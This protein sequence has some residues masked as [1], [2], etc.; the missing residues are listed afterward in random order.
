MAN[1]L[2][3]WGQGGLPAHLTDFFAEESN[4][5]DKVSVPSLSYE[6]KAWTISV[7][8]N[9][10]RIERE[11]DGEMVAV[12][13]MRVIV[14]DYAKRR[15]RAYYPGSY[16]PSKVQ[17]P[18]CWSDDGITPDASVKEPQHS[19]CD[20]CP[21]AIKGSKMDGDKARVACSQHRM[22]AVVPANKLDFTPLRLKLAITSDWDDQS[23]DLEAERWFSFQKYL[24]FLKANRV[25][26][27]AGLVTKMKFDP[28]VQYPKV[29]FSPERP[30][31]AEE[32]EAIKP[33]VKSE[34]VQKLLSG[35]WTPAG[36]DGK[37]VDRS[38]P[39]KDPAAAEKKAAAAATAAPAKEAPAKAA[40][41][42]EEP[43]SVDVSDDD[44]SFVPD[45]LKGK[46]AEG[47]AK[48]APAKAAPPKAAE[49][50]AEKA[51]AKD[52]EITP[53]PKKEEASSVQ[54]DVASLLDTW[55]ED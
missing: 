12:P 44:D 10:H 27:T 18:E 2:T 20:G 21:M 24:D 51:P 28:N 41:P 43:K 53:P 40:P 29:I 13:V 4:I 32:L 52:G 31:T 11:V 49:K 42:K 35:T 55:G 9:K 25:P 37:L 45:F 1:E 50:A 30:V 34:E 14:L 38:E 6:G 48:P 19:K 47:E 17:Q 7:E 23:P 5:A 22:V 3:I 16:D 36:V 15:G 8:G 54:K 39:A 46:K 26:H 33:V